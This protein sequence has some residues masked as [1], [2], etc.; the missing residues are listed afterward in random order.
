MRLLPRFTYGAVAFLL[1]MPSSNAFARE[2]PSEQPSQESNSFSPQAEALFGAARTGN[3]P[4]M[5]KF[6]S[7]DPAII[8]AKNSAGE[9]M[10]QKAMQL[11]DKRAF[12]LL[13]KAGAKPSQPGSIGTTIAYDAAW[14]KDPAWLS[15]LVEAGAD[16]NIVNQPLD[17]FPILRDM[18]P[19]GAALIANRDKQFSLLLKVGADP[20][21]ADRTGNTALHLAAQINKPWH[22]L[23]LLQSGANPNLR[24][25]QG[26]TFQRYLWMTKDHLLNDHT[27]KGRA[28]V[29]AFLQRHGVPIEPMGGTH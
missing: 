18:T 19:L 8:S 25:A 23:A 17:Q 22:V 5:R 21:F 10:L 14:N 7:V 16:P 20:D 3:W 6:V 2:K 4:R 12:R 26:Q 29:V 13:L 1:L 15:M 11:R 24:N 28:A 9:T 27:Q